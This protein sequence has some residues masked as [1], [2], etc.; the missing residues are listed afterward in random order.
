MKTISNEEILNKFI[1]KKGT[2]KREAFENKL[3]AD[4][5]A[6]KFKQQRQKIKLNQEQL[7]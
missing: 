5:L 1:G 3:K 7:S 4:I 2:P 6:H